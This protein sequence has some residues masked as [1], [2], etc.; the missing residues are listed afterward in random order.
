MDVGLEEGVSVMAGSVSW[1]FQFASE[2]IERCTHLTSGWGFNA[3]LKALQTLLAE[4]MSKL[5]SGVH[6][7]KRLCETSREEEWTQLQ[8]AFGLIQVCGD[9][10]LHAETLSEQLY[11]AITSSAT[12]LQ[13]PASPLIPFGCYDYLAVYHPEE[14]TTAMELLTSLQKG[15]SSGV[16]VF[17][18]FIRIQAR[19]CGH[20]LVK[21]PIRFS[22]SMD[23]PMILHSTWFFI[24]SRPSYCVC[25]SWRYSHSPTLYDT[26]M[27][28]Y[29]HKV[30]ATGAS[31][32]LNSP[33]ALSDDLPQFSLSPL[34]YI[35]E[36]CAYRD[37]HT[38]T[39]RVLV[40]THCRLGTI[41]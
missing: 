8:H 3:L 12:K 15:W 33:R 35:T 13:N 18:L 41:C 6:Q 27:H 17:V 21:S 22:L 1:I 34:P 39:W 23:R 10:L 31:S 32:P 4:Y 29:M 40:A 37:T 5:C 7:L 16:K 25:H 26:Y 36:V 2:A 19:R 14:H 9:V 20:C 30:W 11:T 24:L 38:H 28:M